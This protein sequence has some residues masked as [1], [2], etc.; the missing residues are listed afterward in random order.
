MK[1]LISIYPNETSAWIKQIAADRNITIFYS[2]QN[3][4]KLQMN[5]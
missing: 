5:D 2:K 3:D 1:E 4:T